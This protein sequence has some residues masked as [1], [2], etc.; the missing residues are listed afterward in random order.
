MTLAITTTCM[1]L[2]KCIQM[3]STLNRKHTATYNYKWSILY[4]WPHCSLNVSQF[5]IDDKMKVHNKSIYRRLLCLQL[6]ARLMYV[7]GK[8]QIALCRDIC[9]EWKSS[10]FHLSSGPSSDVHITSQCQFWALILMNISYHSVSSGPEFWWTYHFT[11]SALGPSSDGHIT[12]PS[13][14]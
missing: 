4:K 13:D 14:L 2:V 7:H 10:L 9:I 11:M 12:W 3:T 8:C 6:I 5:W 1:E